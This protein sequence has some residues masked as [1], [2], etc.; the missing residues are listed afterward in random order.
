MWGEG[1]DWDVS[2][3]YIAG[4]VTD[5]VRINT[6]DIAKSIPEGGATK[7]SSLTGNSVTRTKILMFEQCYG[8]LSS[9]YLH[10]L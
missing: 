10:D 6:C 5:L 2:Q 8:Q 3:K 9:K 7:V 4:R 1:G